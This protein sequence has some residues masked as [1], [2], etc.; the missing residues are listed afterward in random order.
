[1]NRESAGIEFFG[2]I[3]AS[4]THELNNCLS[5]ID[6]SQGLLADLIAASE[7][8]RAIEPQR[9]KTVQERI[10]RQV[11]NGVAIVGRFNRFA[12]SLDDPAGRFDL[13]GQ[14]DN[15]VA[16]SRRFAEMKKV[17]LACNLPDGEIEISGDPFLLL[18]AV[19]ICL[20]M[21][22]DGSEEGDR[23][24]VSVEQ[25]ESAHVISVASTAKSAVREDD[26]RREQLARLMQAFDGANNIEQGALGGTALM[27]HV[28]ANV[29]GN[30]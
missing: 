19:F 11:R 13:C 12:H 15:I 6:Q 4:V 22:L 8:G 24:E 29:G 21:L 23:L 5:I 1:M 14:T 10:D 20:Q 26:E 27:L 25:G 9:V 30:R 7:A 28:R 17:R 2:A 16:L 3:A 18:Q